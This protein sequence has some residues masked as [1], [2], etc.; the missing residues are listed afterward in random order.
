MSGKRFTI[1]DLDKLEKRGFGISF[2][3]GTSTPK[4]EVKKKFKPV[5]N[6]LCTVIKIPYC[7]AGL[8]GSKGLMRAHFSEVKKQKEK[9][10]TI[11]SA[12]T[13]NRHLGLIRIEFSRFAHRLMDWDNH[14][15]SFKHVGDSL[16][17]CGVIID[18]N[19]KIVTQFV[20][21]QFQIKMAEQEYMI[22][23]I[24]DVE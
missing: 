7:L 4:K 12:Q 2:N 10:K 23:K 13:K 20:P 17:D 21:Y 1:E 19:P 9:L 5:F 6:N 15:A 24:T 11:I 18:D 3:N 8:N 14:C 22:I 16:K